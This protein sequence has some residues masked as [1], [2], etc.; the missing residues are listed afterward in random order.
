MGRYNTFYSLLCGRGATVERIATK[1]TRQITIIPWAVGYLASDGTERF[2]TV[3]QFAAF[4]PITPVVLCAAKTL[5]RG[6]RVVPLCLRRLAFR[7]SETAIET[8]RQYV[9]FFLIN[10]RVVLEKIFGETIFGC[11]SSVGVVGDRW[12]RQVV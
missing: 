9:F 8:R 5:A 6:T 12:P 11:G 10:V 4:K 7:K 3:L 1:P 2:R